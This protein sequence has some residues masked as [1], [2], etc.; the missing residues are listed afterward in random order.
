MVSKTTSAVAWDEER[1]Q[2]GGVLIVCS[3]PHQTPEFVGKNVSLKGEKVRKYL[4]VTAIPPL[5]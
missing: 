3:S 1:L 2:P 5:L 4:L